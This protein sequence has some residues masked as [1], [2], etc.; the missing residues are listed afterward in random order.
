MDS[1]PPNARSMKM[2]HR[3]RR[4][5]AMFI[6]A[7]TVASTAGPVQSEPPSDGPLVASMAL[8]KW[9]PIGEMAPEFR[10][11]TPDGKPVSLV[12]L[13][14]SGPVAVIFLRGWVGKQCPICTG[15]VGSLIARES[16]LKAFNGHVVLIYPGSDEKLSEHAREFMPADLPEQ[17]HLVV[18]PGMGTGSFWGLR[19]DAPGET[20]HPSTFVIDRN[21]RIT[22]LKVSDSHGGRADADEVVAALRKASEAVASSSGSV[23]LSD[24]LAA[25][26]RQFARIAPPDRAA[27][28]EKGVKDV[29]ASGVLSSAKKVGEAAPNFELPDANGKTVSL[30]AVLAEG[31]A[32]MI[33]YRGGWCP[34]CNIEL[35]AFQ[36]RFDEIRSLGAMLVAISPET[37]DHSLDTAERNGLQFVVL[38]DSGNQAAA[39]YG[40]R[41]TLPADLVQAFKGRLDLESFNGDSS[42]TLPLAAAYVVDRDGKIRFASVGADYRERADPDDVIGVLKSLDQEKQP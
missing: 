27:V 18:D 35:R 22:Y 41:Y 29:A 39:A 11:S 31:P 16:E 2:K 3:V 32:V 10:L 24:R 38:S 26:K 30:K 28:Y 9:P 1:G 33:W 19:W 15:Q 5:I 12:E 34:Y 14:A 21:G 36:E 23:P 25:F 40:L 4:R 7:A 42:N 8:T 6:V 17:F 20:V 13:E 37:P